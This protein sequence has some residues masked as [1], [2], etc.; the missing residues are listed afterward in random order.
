MEKRELQDVYEEDGAREGIVK[1]E[2]PKI[3]LDQLDVTRDL[4]NVRFIL[5]S[6]IKESDIIYYLQIKRWDD[7]GLELSF[8]FSNPLLISQGDTRDIAEVTIK[9]PALFRS[10]ETGEMIDVSKLVIY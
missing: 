2:I 5:N 4:F 6:E 10:A 3:P 7:S 8:N 1:V 9:N